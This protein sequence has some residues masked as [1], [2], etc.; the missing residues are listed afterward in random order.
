MAKLI[1][2]PTTF[3][4]ATNTWET[5]VP[6]GPGGD[7]FLDGLA[8]QVPVAFPGGINPVTWQGQFS[9]DT[10]GVRIM[11]MPGKSSGS[12]SISS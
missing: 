5:T 11:W 7:A 4:T 6:T 9:S 2:V 1:R 8:F 3:D 12:P 10:P